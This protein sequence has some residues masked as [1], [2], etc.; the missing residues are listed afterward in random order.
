METY[1]IGDPH[2]CHKNII[3]YCNR[4][5]ETVNEMNETL[6]SN[7][8]KTVGKQD[9]VYC[10]GDFALCGKDK[11]VEIGQRLNG[12]KR[13]ILGNHDGASLKTYR[14]AGFE[15]VYNHPILVDDFYIL[16]HMPQH[17]QPD[18]L[19]A[20]IYAHVHDDPSY[21]DVS[22]RSFCASSERIEYKPIL[23]SEIKNAMSKCE[24]EEQ[25]EVIMVL[26]DI[27]G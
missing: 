11:L 6:I 12:R 14:D 4:P 3:K 26:E 7:W 20:N 18:G 2:F 16:S 21:K 15:Y 24:S 5:F 8:N 9:I 22:P 17:V 1:L 10:L 25:E 23:L 19:Y 27:Y 13:L